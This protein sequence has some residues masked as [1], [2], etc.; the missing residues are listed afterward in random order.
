MKCPFCK[1][2]DD[3]VIDSRASNE[4]AVVR[5][6]LE[7]T[8]CDR[9]YTTYERVEETPILVIKKGGER[10]PYDRSK[11]LSGIRKACEKRPVSAESQEAIVLELE[12]LIDDKYEREVSSSVVGEFLMKKLSAIDEVAYVRFASVYRQFKDINHFMK[13]LKTLLSK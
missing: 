5:R 7:C 12:K 11:V 2:D 8:K 4:G 6:R 13:E 3:K 1:H 10:E 9:R